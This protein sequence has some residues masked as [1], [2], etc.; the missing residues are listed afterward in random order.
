MKRRFLSFLLSVCMVMTLLPV[1]AFAVQ[2]TDPMYVE[3]EMGVTPEMATALVDALVGEDHGEAIQDGSGYKFELSPEMSGALN[4]SMAVTDGVE[5]KEA[6][7]AEGDANKVPDDYEDDSNEDLEALLEELI[8]IPMPL[9]A[10]S[11]ALKKVDL[12]FLIDSTGSMY[13]SIRDVKN[14]VAE[15]AQKIDASGVNLRLG[16]ID[17]RDITVDGADSTTLHSPSLTPWLDVPA[18]I[19]ELT[20]VDA[21]GGGDTDETPIDALANLTTGATGWNSDA[22]KFAVLITDAGYKLDNNHGIADMDEMIEK[23]VAENIQVSTITPSF[24]AWDYGELAAYTGGV[25]IEL[26]GAFAKDLLDYANTVIGSALAVTRDYTLRVLDYETGLPVSGASVRWNGGSAVSDADGIVK[27]TT[28][29]HPVENVIITYP[30]YKTN[31]LGN[32]YDEKYD[33]K[34]ASMELDDSSIDDAIDKGETVDTPV[35]NKSMFVNPK[36]GSSGS[37]ALEIDFLGKNFNLLEKLSFGFNVDFFGYKV[38]INNDTDEKKFEAMIGYQWDRAESAKGDSYW[39]DDY[40]KYKSLVQNFSKKSAKD[41]Y[42]DFRKMRTNAKNLTSMRG[43]CLFPVDLTVG[44]FWE[45]SYA[46][47]ELVPTDGGVIV[48]VSTDGT[49]FEW[50]IP[51]AP[52]IFFKL[53]FG[54][55]AKGRFTF[56]HVDDSA[57]VMF[58]LK[59]R[60]T[61]GP[62]LTGTVNLGVPKLASVGGGLKGSLEAQLDIPFTKLEDGLEVMMKGSVILTLDLLGFRAAEADLPFGD[63]LRLFPPG[64]GREAV[65]SLASISGADFML[66]PRPDISGAES[67]ADND[68]DYYQPNVYA[69]SAPQLLHMADGTLLLVWID[70]VTDR[71]DY[72]MA[73]LYYSVKDAST[74]EWSTPALVKDDGTSDYMPSLTLS[75]EGIPV[76][77]WQNVHETWGSTPTL[78]DVAKNIDLTSMSFDKTT[79]TFADPVS[80]ISGNA[81]NVYETAV[82]LT[83]DTAYWLE[84]TADNPLLSV[85]RAAIMKNSLSGG[86]P[87]KVAD[88]ELVDGLNGFA[89]GKIG[90]TEYTAY[91]DIDRIHYYDGSRWDTIPT[92]GGSAGLQ[93]A[94]GKMYWSDENGL[95]SWDGS[96]VRTE[97]TEL[98]PAEFTVLSNGSKKMMLIRQ[99]TGITNELYSSQYSDGRWTTPVPVT[100]YGRSIGAAGVV[101]DEDKLIWTC[102]LTN[103]T[104]EQMDTQSDLIVDSCTPAAKV[105][106]VDETAYVS[107]LDIIPGET[108]NVSVRIANLGLGNAAGLVAELSYNGSTTSSDLYILDAEGTRLETRLDSLDPGETLWVE[109]KFLLPADLSSNGELAITIKDSS[110]ICGTAKTDIPAAAADIVVENTTV[111]RT[112]SG[113]NVTATVKNIG[114]ANAAPV[115]VNLSM[116]GETSSLGHE[117]ITSLAVGASQTVTFAVPAEKL[118]A[119]SPYDNKSFTVTV[120]PV[121]GETMTGNNSGTV[122]LAPA[123]AESITI[124]SEKNIDMKGGETIDLTC[125]VTPTGVPVSLSWMSTNIAIAVVDKDGKVIARGDGEADIIV[126]AADAAGVKDT[127]RDSVHIRV[128]EGLKTGVD[129]VSITPDTASIRVGESVKLKAVVLPESALNQNVTWHMDASD[130]VR[131]KENDDGTITVTGLKEGSAIVTA[132]TSD[133]SFTA[134]AVI[135]VSKASTIISHPSSGSSS[136]SMKTTEYRVSTPSGIK[137]GSVSVS[138]A[139]ASRNETVT[140]TVKPDTGYQ[141]DR[142]KVTDKSGKEVKLHEQSEN[143]YTFTMPNCDVSIDVEFAAVLEQ[144]STIL[145][146]TDVFVSDPSYEAVKYVYEKGIMTGTSDTA[147]SPNVV[148]S[149]GMIVSILH[150]LEKEPAATGISFPDVASGSWYERAIAWASANGI[151]SGYSNGSFGPED[152]ITKEQLLSILNRYAKHKGYPLAGSAD[153]S[154]YQDVDSVSNYALES[155]E[156]A[157][158]QSLISNTQ[159][160]DAP[161]QI[162]R[163]QA[164]DILMRFC[165]N[166]AGQ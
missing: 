128:T 153:L 68:F 28:N 84:T 55:D 106:V 166:V 143:K 65:Y 18:F 156:W 159:R 144:P 49:L 118:A 63:G 5:T 131:L 94:D 100:D 73:G 40:N 163:V 109:A 48:G 97:S 95:H 146:Y 81:N 103:A 6:D 92:S 46:T 25:Q 61:A 140:I 29:K 124:D 90:S 87:S 112:H 108:V 78:N 72:N 134:S 86:M 34:I 151:V 120:T 17:F 149:R 70:A 52:Y 148:I 9:S 19:T 58:T 80:V 85:G 8:G 105:V 91:A 111:N 132:V 20:K 162:T 60:I 122:I 11:A 157:V 142:L 99:N 89:A 35:L 57:K 37:G 26:S 154:G 41:I 121:S 16:L 135:R 123:E 74:G 119:K 126:S 67:L 71:S 155:I 98:K 82:Q 139:R 23:L 114:Y 110:G 93:I 54:L 59:S 53:D 83:P 160:L 51:P 136:I 15:F 104:E 116:E 88:I 147:F 137:N 62:Q 24:V 76:V 12:F 75:S 64:K 47:G 10:E 30:G 13:N 133:G 165:Q 164:A 33:V 32:L 66:L 14:N 113:A 42:N 96:S 4:Q 150:R 138:P 158:A 39:K 161:I 21:V 115:E 77:V 3:G 69:D 107:A 7:V 1:S 130:A 125:I 79:K 129:S 50:P 43:Q 102:G 27:I 36:S 127:L 2:E 145:P 101:L 117:T 141:L 44:G 31:Y 38:E 45:A 22:Y 152:T 56:I